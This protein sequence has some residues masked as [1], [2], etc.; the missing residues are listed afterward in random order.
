MRMKLFSA[1]ALAVA[2]AGFGPRVA[3]AEIIWS[4]IANITATSANSPQSFNGGAWEWGVVQGG[5]VHYAYMTPQDPGTSPY[6]PYV[7]TKSAQHLKVENLAVGTIIDGSTSGFWNS[8]P[9]NG[10]AQDNLELWDFANSTGAFPLDTDGYAAMRLSDGAGG[11]TYGWTE[12][13][14]NTGGTLTFIQQ[15]FQDTAGVGIAVGAVPE[16]EP[17]GIGSALAL[18]LG[19]LGMIERRRQQATASV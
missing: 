8:Y 4:G 3:E 5:P 18:A 17:A 2:L 1:A 11:F 9:T 7:L 14:V 15:A 6:V 16:I 10:G 13:R 12:F 19:V